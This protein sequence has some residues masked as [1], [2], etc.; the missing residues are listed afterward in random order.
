M[1][2][3][4]KT[5]GV[6]TSGGDAPGMNPAVRAVVRSAI[7]RGIHVYGIQRGYQGLLDRSISQMTLRTVS[8]IMGR[9]GTVLYSSR[10]PEFQTEQGLQRAVDTCREFALDGLVTLGG[11]GTFRGAL[12]LAK[13]G[14][15]CIGLPVTID[16]DIGCSQYSIGFDTATNTAIEMIDRIRDTSQ[17]H[18]R[19]TVVEVMGRRCG[20]LA[21]NA[22]IACGACAILIP[23]VEFDFERDVIQKI[24]A[25]Q[26]TGKKHF[27][28]I[29]AEGIGGVESIA[30][31]IEYATGITSRFAVLGHVQRGGSPSARDRIIASEMG[32][33]AV[34][35]LEKGLGSHIVAYK[36][37]AIIDLE[38]EKAL[39][40]KKEI[41]MHLLAVA[42]EVSV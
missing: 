25:L 4:I 20:Q 6:L 36:D 12:E 22:G 32:V 37:G 14:V 35:L 30:K 33:R 29:V 1:R 27:I 2:K 31:S 41:D 38:I 21:L 15:Q 26:K 17:S 18:D 5:I 3:R 39:A 34:D 23:E 42:Q 8:E 28:I 24:I 16:N 10:C 7:H 9:G 11:D 13:R 40:M 19:C